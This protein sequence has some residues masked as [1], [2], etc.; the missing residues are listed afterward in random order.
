MLYQLLR[1]HSCLPLAARMLIRM[2]VGDKARV[3]AT[4]RGRSYSRA[5]DR[6]RC[7]DE[8]AWVDQR[9]QCSGNTGSIYLLLCRLP[10]PGLLWPNAGLC[11]PVD[12]TDLVVLLSQYLK[13]S[14]MYTPCN[15]GGYY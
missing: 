10:D 14:Y 3:R 1:L 9:R 11:F 4:R 8:A 5:P 13:G 12:Q 7:A 6:D 2:S 15:V